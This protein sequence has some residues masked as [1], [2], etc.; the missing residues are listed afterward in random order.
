[1]D[2]VFILKSLDTIVFRFLNL[3]RTTM[4]GQLAPSSSPLPLLLSRWR[5]SSL[6]LSPSVYWMALTPPLAATLCEPRT[7]VAVAHAFLSLFLRTSLG[8]VAPSLID[9]VWPLPSSALHTF[10]FLSRSVA[11]AHELTGH[12]RY[13]QSIPSWRAAQC[14]LRSRWRVRQWVAC[15]RARRWVREGSGDYAR[16]GC[17]WGLCLVEAPFGV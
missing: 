12:E 10:T 17:E 11:R 6:Q 5:W 1:M 16:D 14:R 7:S 9:H 2:F 8:A 13:L 3:E 4:L 15:W